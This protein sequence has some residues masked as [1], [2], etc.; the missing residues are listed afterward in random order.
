MKAKRSLFVFVIAASVMVTMP[1]SVSGQEH[2]EGGGGG[3]GCGDVFGD[4]IHIL[5]HETTGQPILAQRWVEMPAELPGYGWGYCPIAVYHEDG[6]L[7]EFPFLPFS[8]DFDLT[9][10]ED[11]EGDP[12][13]VEEV[14]YFGRLNGGRTKERNHRMHLDEVISTIKQAGWVTREVTG[15]LKIGFDCPLP[16]DI[17]DTCYD[18]ATV[19]SPM[20]SMALYTRVMK[21]G[22]LA[23]DPYEVNTWSHGDPKL[24]THFHPALDLEDWDKFDVQL[25]NLKPDPKEHGLSEL[26]ECWDYD[27]AE[28]MSD[29]DGDGEW[30]PYE[31][32]YD[33]DEDCT[34]DDGEPFEDLDL[35]GTWNSGEA[36]T[37]LNNN[38]VRDDFKFL[39]AGPE[40]LEEKDFIS[41]SVLLAAAAS[42]TGFITRDLVQYANRILKITKNTAHTE[43]TVDT[44]P[45][46]VRDCW[47]DDSDPFPP[48]HEPEPGDPEPSYG[49]CSEYDADDTLPN[50]EHFPDAQE[51]FVD[52]SGLSDYQ[53]GN[54][55]HDVNVLMNDPA[56]TPALWEPVTMELIKDWLNFVNGKKT[57]N[58]NIDGFV[59]ATSDVLRSIEFIHNYDVPE[60][61][62]CKYDPAE[63]YE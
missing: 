23:T 32:F 29:S 17:G 30:D 4:L 12:L 20:E 3:G 49:V 58:S 27:Q 41:G 34:W 40:P 61:L 52:F 1:L 13:E 21:Y 25:N 8:C 50:Y 10:P 11:P 22:H 42:K 15:R 24:L 26:E 16:G 38:C 53:R 28:P 44:L 54:L 18:W 19:D 48:D 31:P 60:D 14:N 35:S 9:N 33:M 37:D 56:N 59:D 62:F 6:E 51:R 45:A 55:E 63:C 7:K 5:R 2:E 39:C 47:P 57:S 36:F 43:A 46:R